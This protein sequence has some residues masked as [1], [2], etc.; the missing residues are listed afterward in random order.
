M[1]PNQKSIFILFA[2]NRA[3]ADMSPYCELF[4]K[5]DIPVVYLYSHNDDLLMRGIESYKGFKIKSVDSSIDEV[6]ELGE[7]FEHKSDGLPPAE[8]DEFMKFVKDAIGSGVARVTTSKRLYNQACVVSGHASSSMKDMMRMLERENADQ[9]NQIKNMMQQ[10]NPITLEIN[11]NHQMIVK[12]NGV[13]KIDE[14]V[15]KDIANQLFENAQV[16][17]GIIEDPKSM[18]TRIE[19]FMGLALDQAM[20]NKLIG[21]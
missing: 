19:K 11:P 21:K 3:E 1:K 16:T 2:K 7:K 20:T 4:K 8:L 6:E 12:L 15:A 13:R 17:A 5:N 10:Q 18:L 9:Y 14:E